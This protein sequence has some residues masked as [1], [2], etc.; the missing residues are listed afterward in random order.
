MLLYLSSICYRNQTIMADCIISLIT[1][2]AI[3]VLTITKKGD[4]I[5]GYLSDKN[6]VD[7]MNHL[8]KLDIELNKMV[9]KSHERSYL[10]VTEE[11]L[12]PIILITLMDGIRTIIGELLTIF[13]CGLLQKSDD[14]YTQAWIYTEKYNKIK[15]AFNDLETP[16]VINSGMSQIYLPGVLNTRYNL[17]LQKSQ[18]NSEEGIIQKWLKEVETLTDEEYNAEKF[19]HN[20]KSKSFQCY[21]LSKINAAIGETPKD[22][23]SF[24]NFIKWL[25]KLIPDKFDMSK[26]VYDI[27]VP[28]GGCD[29]SV[30]YE[31]RYEAIKLCPMINNIVEEFLKGIKHINVQWNTGINKMEYSRRASKW[32]WNCNDSYVVYME[33]NLCFHC[34]PITENRNGAER[35]YFLEDLTKD[36]KIEENFDMVV[37]NSHNIS[38][39]KD[40]KNI[41]LKSQIKNIENV[42]DIQEFIKNILSKI[43]SESDLIDQYMNKTFPQITGK[44]VFVDG[45]KKARELYS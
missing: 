5:I 7:F 4:D 20:N 29:M 25:N 35:W 16:V 42:E 31:N 8:I 17:L 34:E 22:D 11:P 9:R 10:V 3:P 28:A 23:M 33:P 21:I 44:W 32:G 15:A 45:W 1:G 19:F 37:I 24:G 14:I 39:K 6:F 38:I 13:P 18:E 26:A 40:L 43:P 2:E 41:W 12:H 36:T 27:N 30:K